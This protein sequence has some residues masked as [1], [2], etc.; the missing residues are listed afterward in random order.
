MAQQ[1]AVRIADKFL[2]HYRASTGSFSWKPFCQGVERYQVK[3]PLFA[4]RGEFN[5]DDRAIDAV[6]ADLQ[7]RAEVPRQIVRTVLERIADAITQQGYD[8]FAREARSGG[9]FADGVLGTNEQLL[10][11]IPG[12][13]KGQCRPLLLAV[14][15]GGKGKTG[16]KAIAKQIRLH[17]TECENITSSVLIVTDEWGPNIMGDSLDDFALRARKGVRFS[18][19]MCPQPGQDLV[20]LPV[21]I[22]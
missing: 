3:D 7:G 5:M 11:V 21:N 17:L 10:N 19:I 15:R 22:R 14:A 12:N 2:R 13:S 8:G 9:L 6:V 16:M 1:Q 18:V 20:R 4:F